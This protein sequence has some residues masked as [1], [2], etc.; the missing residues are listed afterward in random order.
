MMTTLT[1]M[2]MSIARQRRQQH[3]GN[4]GNGNGDD[5]NNNDNDNDNRDDDNE[6]GDVDEYI[7]DDDDED[8]DNDDEE[9]GDIE[10]RYLLYVPTYP[11][12]SPFFGERF[13]ELCWIEKSIFGSCYLSTIFCPSFPPNKNLAILDRLRTIP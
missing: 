4:D 3:G 2:T 9:D 1:T 10:C 8:D 11:V 7:G 5:N 12:S 13:S 6:N